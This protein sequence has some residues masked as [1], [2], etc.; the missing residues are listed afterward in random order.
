M[1]NL[2]HQHFIDADRAERDQARAAKRSVPFG[3]LAPNANPIRACC[4]SHSEPCARCLQ[5]P[6]CC[7]CPGGVQDATR[8]G[9]EPRKEA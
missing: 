9:F 7:D 4:R 3:H 2:R 8:D 6:E 1:P 5:C